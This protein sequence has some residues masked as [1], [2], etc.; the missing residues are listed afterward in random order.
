MTFK[1]QEP[2][3]PFSPFFG[4]FGTL[5]ALER[6]WCLRFRVAVRSDSLLAS[7]A[8]LEV[9]LPLN[10]YDHYTQAGRTAMV[11]N[12]HSRVSFYNWWVALREAGEPNEP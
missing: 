8:V 6:S 9:S 3:F 11:S 2:V 5:R 7:P 4:T 10:W 12:L 1:V